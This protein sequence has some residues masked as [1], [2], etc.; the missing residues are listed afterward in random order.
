MSSLYAPEIRGGGRKWM[1]GGGGRTIHG[2]N[3]R[4]PLASCHP[5]DVCKDD[6]ARTL[7]QKTYNSNSITNGS[8]VGE[9]LRVRPNGLAWW[10]VSEVRRARGQRYEKK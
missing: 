6:E 4:P 9:G 2:R 5:T 3:L 8:H 7:L 1:K 10:D